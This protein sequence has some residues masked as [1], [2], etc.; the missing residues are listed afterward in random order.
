MP[1]I[2]ERHST[3]L[4]DHVLPHEAALRAWVRA[5]FSRQVE[6]DD[7]V[8]ETW[9]IFATIGNIDQVRHPRAYM[10]RVARSV[11]LQQLRRARI[12]TIEAVAEMDQLAIETTQAGPEQHAASH[13]ALRQTGEM[14]AA[15]PARCRQAFMLRKI[16]GLSQREIAQHMSISESTVEKHLSKALRLLMQAMSEQAQTPA[17]SD[18]HRTNRRNARK[19]D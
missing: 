8:Q 7:V 5:H 10:F 14:I 11:I 6:V 15:L 16:D 19:H 12:V 1:R 9:A 4:A 18:Q 13:Q 3:W 2:T 17:S